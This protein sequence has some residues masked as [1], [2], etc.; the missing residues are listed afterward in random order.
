M[1]FEFRRF[2]PILSLGLVLGAIDLPTVISFAI[3]IYSGELAPF[4]GVG[5]GMVL[6]GGLI[7][8]LMI[9]F[10]T[11]IPGLMG[12]PQDSPAAILGIMA[13]AILSQIP[14]ASLQTKF[15]TVTAMVVLTSVLS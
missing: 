4:A 2:I 15:A 5:I 10:S 14:N 11:S 9:A 7:I 3:L 6:F 13:A 1:K 8:Q 12:G